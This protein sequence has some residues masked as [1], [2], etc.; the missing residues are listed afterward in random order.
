MKTIHKYKLN[1]SGNR[2][3]VDMAVGAIILNVDVP[4]HDIMVWAEV[5]DQAPLETVYFD[6]V[7]TGHKLTPGVNREF[8]GT[9]IFKFTGLVFHVYLIKEDK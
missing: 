3:A 5:D 7:G 9:T 6:V 2:F 1:M 4:D 8:V